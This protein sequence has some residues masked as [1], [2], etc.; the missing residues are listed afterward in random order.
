M[1]GKKK[2]NLKEETVT[3][4]CH[5]VARQGLYGKFTRSIFGFRPAYGDAVLAETSVDLQQT[6]WPESEGRCI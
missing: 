5:L 1:E 4:T 6:T 2:K 3:S